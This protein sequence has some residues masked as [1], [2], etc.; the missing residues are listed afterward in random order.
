ME[1]ITQIAISGIL[2]IAL[3]IV[4]YRLRMLTFTGALASLLVGY[5]VGLF[6][7]IEWLILLVVF[8]SAG[9]A[10]T[11]LYLSDKSELGLQEGNFGE[12]THSNVLGVGIPACAFAVAYGVLHTMLNG[13]Y[14]LA[15]TVAFIS[16]LTVAAADTVASELGMRDRKVWLITTFERVRRGTNG[17][18]SVLGI[19]SSAAASAFT[20]AV[21]YLL[22]LKGIDVY[23]LV[24]IAM[25]V[26]GSTVDSLLG[27][28][29][30]E[31]GTISK[32]TNNCVSGFIGG[33]LGLLIVLFL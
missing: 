1:M 16:T 5:T 17:G 13:K 29:L 7:S 9:L 30:E 6:G 18:V 22:I 12:R 11:K 23:V 20:G 26:L 25:G 31:R 28:T 14:D 4:A 21:G 27:A 15:L 19:V 2:S 32:Y 3:S 8:T 10:V 24:P 33:I